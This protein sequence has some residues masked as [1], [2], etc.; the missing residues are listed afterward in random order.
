M[1]ILVDDVPSAEEPEPHN[2]DYWSARFPRGECIECSPA[3][4]LARTFRAMRRTGSRMDA[5][6]VGYYKWLR[7]T[8]LQ[9]IGEEDTK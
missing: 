8:N 9:T 3:R 7:A 5:L 2:D 6:G 4:S 1:T